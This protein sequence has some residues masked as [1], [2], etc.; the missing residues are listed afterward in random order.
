MV[1]LP[2]TA[3]ILDGHDVIFLALPHGASGELAGQLSDTAL[4][5]D[6]GADHRLEDKKQWDAFY[7]GAYYSAWTYGV[8][9]LP[10]EN[11]SQ[12]DYL[13]GTRRIAAPGCNASA[14]TLAIAPGIRA[15]L[16]DALD[17]VS[18]L[19]VGTS[20]AGKSLKPELLASEILGSASA[21]AVGGIH[22]H[23]PEIIQNLHK[24]GADHVSV[25]MTP[26]LVPMSRGILAITTA[27]IKPG[28]TIEKLHEAWSE[29]Y[30]NEPFVHVL[31]LGS[32]PR[33]QDTVGVN[34]CL[35]GLALDEEVGRVVV[36]SALDNLTK[37][38]AGA[39][40]QS[41]NIA[42]GIPETTALTIDGVAP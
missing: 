21:Y 31:P 3:D 33:T 9:E 16:I 26:M 40:I 2:T 17:I 10:L 36:V 6:C 15:G 24:A 5:I 38:T 28:V 34:T 25:S 8:P 42:L 32:F 7:G 18:M 37:G 27:R 35:M 29:A 11:G 30:A 13:R 12:R 39:A 41:A 14:V 1:L 4:V 23:T 22:R 19:S 20:G